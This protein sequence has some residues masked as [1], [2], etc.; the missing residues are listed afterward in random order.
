MPPPLPAP[1]PRAG[2]SGRHRPAAPVSPRE[3]E[4]ERTP[5]PPS[6]YG[7]ETMRARRAAA[8]AFPG[9]PGRR[10]QSSSSSGAGADAAARS[11]GTRT[12][13]PGE[14]PDSPGPRACGARG[15]G[16]FPRIKTVAAPSRKLVGFPLNPFPVLKV[17]Q[18]L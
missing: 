10:S 9:A 12:A 6:C 13:S 3:R 18:S 8:R 1:V 17:K 14:R 7:A 2:Q 15:S 11:R 4:P 5:T 16:L